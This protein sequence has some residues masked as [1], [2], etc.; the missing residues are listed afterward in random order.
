MTGEEPSQKAGPQG[1]R[2]VRGGDRDLVRDPGGAAEGDLAG[3][4]IEGL[5]R[6]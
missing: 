5:Y 3:A 2:A 1:Q 6:G 4:G